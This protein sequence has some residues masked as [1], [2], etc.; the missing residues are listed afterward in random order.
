MLVFERKPRRR[1]TRYYEYEKAEMGLNRFPT[2][3]QCIPPRNMA[4]S[5]RRGR[6]TWP[7]VKLQCK[8]GKVVK[9]GARAWPRPRGERGRGFRG[10]GLVQTRSGR[11]EG[12]MINASLCVYIQF[13]GVFSFY[14]NKCIADRVNM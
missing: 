11:R 6:W 7:R 10:E 12:A 4:N 9:D 14:S 2:L 5:G 8:P 13:S 3:F 1:L